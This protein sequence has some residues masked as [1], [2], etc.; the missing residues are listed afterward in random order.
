MKINRLTI[1]L[2]VLILSVAVGT[3]VRHIA[4][5]PIGSQIDEDEGFSMSCPWLVRVS[6][7]A[8]YEFDCHVFNDSRFQ[9]DVEVVFGTASSFVEDSANDRYVMRIQG[10]TLFP[11]I[12]YVRAD[13][14]PLPTYSGSRTG[15]ERARTTM[16]RD[17]E[18]A[19]VSTSISIE[20]N[21]NALL[22]TGPG[23]LNL[24][25]LATLVGTLLYLVASAR[26]ILMNSVFL[27]RSYL[28]VDVFYLSFLLQVLLM[29]VFL[30]AFTLSRAGYPTLDNDHWVSFL[31]GLGWFVFLGWL[32]YF[33]RWRLFERVV[34]REWRAMPKAEEVSPALKEEPPRV[35]PFI[36]VILIGWL[37]CLI[38]LPI[39]AYWFGWF[40]FW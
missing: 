8:P 5:G 29:T 24:Q 15:T 27:R 21:Y 11:D 16:Y 18:L 2:A 6:A 19:T 35:T 25:I 33:A 40:G 36:G 7:G 13:I 32:V 37:F 3:G 39:N 14:K 31:I 12:R 17:D 23:L 4:S 10:E 26:G 9:D 30:F 34:P 28:V 20:L 38:A 22:H 1:L